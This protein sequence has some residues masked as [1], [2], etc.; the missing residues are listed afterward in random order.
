M[1]LKFFFALVCAIVAINGN[2]ALSQIFPRGL[3]MSW[4]EV[5]E[6]KPSMD[7][8]VEVVR[9]SKFD[10]TMM[11]G[12]DYTLLNKSIS[13][14]ILKKKACAYSDGDT[15]YLNCR[16]LKAQPLYAKVYGY[17]KYLLFDAGYSKSTE[18]FDVKLKEMFVG[19]MFGILG[20]A[21]LGGVQAN[22]RFSY[23]FDMDACKLYY[24]DVDFL[25]HALADS[26]VADQIDRDLDII[27]N[28]TNLEQREILYK[29]FVMRYSP[30]INK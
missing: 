8:E 18:T 29:Q 15:L 26:E 14:K 16:N 30:Y 21:I 24:V 27:K 6:H 19:Y 7:C 20:G 25:A 22:Q 5:R 12:N 23:A 3:Y 4:Q 11:G 9:R 17:G 13:S 28:V 1:K 10:I 2:I